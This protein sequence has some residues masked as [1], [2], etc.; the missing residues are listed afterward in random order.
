MDEKEIVNPGI[1]YERKDLRLRWILA[2][3]AGVCCFAVFHYY[4]T[5]RLMWWRE[6]AARAV[7]QSPYRLAPTLS[8]KLPPEPRLEQLD[9]L[10]KIETSDVSRML[11]DKEKILNSYGPTEEKGFIHIPIQEAMK[12][13]A[14]TLPVRESSSNE[15]I[16]KRDVP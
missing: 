1:H 4:A 10:A 15:T 16:Q 12:R 9:R 3:I 2:L 7:N 6:N 14:G 13:V 8:T 11:T 5:W